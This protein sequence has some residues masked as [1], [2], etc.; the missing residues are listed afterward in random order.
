MIN[1]PSIYSALAASSILGY[2]CSSDVPVGLKRPYSNETF[3]DT[4]SYQLGEYASK[5][6]YNWRHSALMPWGDV[7]S[8]WYPVELYR[9]LLSEADDH[10]VTIASIGFLDNLS[11][12]L[13]SPGDIYSPLSGHDL[14]KAK[15]EELVIMGG[16]YPCGYEY[17]FYG[18][19]ATAT[20]HVVNTWPGPMTFSGSELGATVYSGARLTVEGPVGDPV[21]AAYRWYTGYNTSRSSWDP[22]TVLYAIEGRGKMFAYADERGHNYVYP[23]GRNE[24]L[25]G[26]PLSPQRYLKLRMS[27][28]QAGDFLDDFYLDTAK[29]AARRSLAKGNLGND[30]KF[31]H[32]PRQGRL[33]DQLLQSSV[34]AA[35]VGAALVAAVPV[36]EL[37]ARDSCT[38]TSAADAKSGKAS[39]STITLSNIEVPAGET[40]DLTD[41]NEGTTVIFSGETTFGYKE[42]EGPLISVSGTNIKVQQ[43][44]GAKID[45]DGARWWDGKGGNGGK[46]K[47]KFFSAHKLDSSS[48][49]GLKIYNTPVQ[50]FSIQS[51]NLN[52]TDV[53]ID[54]SAGTDQGHNT[55][56]FDV[57][58][59]TYI[60]IDGATVYNQDDCLA[61]N[62][63]SHITFTNGYCDGGHGLSIG[64]VGG[65]SDNTVEDVTISNSKVVNSQNGV[66]I[67]TVYDATGTVSNVKF[68]DITLSGITKY[69]LIVEQDYE[70]GSPTGTPTNGIKVS[71]I[72]F[73][74]VT[75][76]VESDATD[77]YIL[78]GS[79][80]CTDWT[81]SGVSITGGKTSSKCENV[82]TG[83]S[84]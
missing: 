5:V 77:I 26:N 34:L 32:Q 30:I 38:F 61:I 8:A 66:R 12:L 63:G 47:P 28:T 56:A 18:N 82:P 43:E 48:I 9:K 31:Q 20:A 75:G 70:N 76:T 11:E 15:V 3:F 14:V 84:C 55:D 19:N 36:P 44:S 51:D 27:E 67:K 41:L 25:P 13:S 17:N 73:E 29:R 22:L 35:T 50:G 46:T 74:K 40:L 49:T 58:S 1:Y 65:R 21:K 33:V 39:C 2:Y 54:N 6:A 71:D 24:W 16:A 4:W 59:S 57:G 81:W 62:S 45:G 83:A 78:C 64:S 79:G 68:Q 69:G 10:S 23:D 72:T 7:S 52:I 60:T 42:W 37:E 80:S 53:T